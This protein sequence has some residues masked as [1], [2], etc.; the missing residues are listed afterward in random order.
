MAPETL[1]ETIAYLCLKL[2]NNKK[3]LL[4]HFKDR[5][6][7]NIYRKNIVLVTAVLKRSKNFS[8]SAV[9]RPPSAIALCR[10]PSVRPPPSALR[11]PL[12]V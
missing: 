1:M 7:F 11:P 4:T 2:G 6:S 10:P 5:N 12:L 8:P 3:L 9:R